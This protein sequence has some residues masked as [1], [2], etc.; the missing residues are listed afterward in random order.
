MMKD[1]SNMTAAEIQDYMTNA[2]REE[3]NRRYEQNRAKAKAFAEYQREMIKDLI[4]EEQAGKDVMIAAVRKSARARLQCTDSYFERIAIIKA[5]MN[6]ES[7]LNN[8][9]SK[10]KGEYDEICRVCGR[11][12]AEIESENAATHSDVIPVAAAPQK[13]RL[14]SVALI[15]VCGVIALVLILA[16]TGVIAIAR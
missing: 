9:E 6:S 3:L 16:I 10:F 4:N 7:Q 13:S 5:C 11:I 1:F 14:E 8:T 12:E 2:S 15:A